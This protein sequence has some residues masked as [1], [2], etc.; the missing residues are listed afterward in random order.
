[1][2]KKKILFCVR[3]FAHGGIPRCLQQLLLKI[4]VEKYDINVYCGD[5]SGIYKNAFSNATILK[6]SLLMWL[7][8]TNYRKQS[9]WRK[10]A[11]IA[12]KL[13]RYALLKLNFDLFDWKIKW[14]ARKLSN[15]N[16]DAYIAFSEG[17]PTKLISWVS[18]PNKFVWIHCD[19]DWV[20][21]YENREEELNYYNCFD[22][23]V[24]VSAFT[25]NAFDRAFPTLSERT[26]VIYNV[27]DVDRIKSLSKENEEIDKRYDT[28]CFTIISVGRICYQKQFEVIPKIAHV[29][30]ENGLNFKWYIIGIGPDSEMETVIK[31]LDKYGIEDS[32][33]LLGPKNNPYPYMKLADLFVLTSRYESYPTVINESK[34]VG[35]P[36]VS[37]NFSSAYE[38]MNEDCGLVYPV[39]KLHLGIIKMKENQELYQ[40]IKNKLAE[41]KY[42]N[43][44]LLKQIYA[45]ID[46][47]KK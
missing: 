12:I 39:E 15:Y 42:D 1:M 21:P 45:L 29:L 16:Y 11:A 10:I 36:I 14:D 46:N 25:K 4:D 40:L 9:G 37:T 18:R 2:E 8:M 43:A 5:Q 35:T 13:L 20:S 7:L 34:I 47:D 32:V 17:F 24:C 41:F 33:I 26:L 28:N 6:E 44:S 22:N 23:I 27:I 3:D 38:I 31:E 19:Y 30:K